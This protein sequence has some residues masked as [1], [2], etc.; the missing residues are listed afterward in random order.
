LQKLAGLDD[1]SRIDHVIGRAGFLQQFRRNRG[2]L[3]A[4]SNIQLQDA[5]RLVRVL[6][7]CPD[8][9]LG[10]LQ[11]VDPPGGYPHVRAAGSELF[12]QRQADPAGAT[13]DENQLIVEL[14]S[15]KS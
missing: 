8:L 9:R 11:L 3:C 14:G 6:A 12:R 5:N 7:G 13:G 2:D 1:A 10:V 4:V 15:H